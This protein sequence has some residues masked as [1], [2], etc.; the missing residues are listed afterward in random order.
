MTLNFD[1]GTKL[2]KITRTFAIYV[3]QFK[4]TGQSDTKPPKRFYVI[5]NIFPFPVNSTILGNFCS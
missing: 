4:K 1:Q 3:D 2:L 5:K